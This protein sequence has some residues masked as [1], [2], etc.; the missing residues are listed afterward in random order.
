MV[1]LASTERQSGVIAPSIG[2][3]LKRKQSDTN[4]DADNLPSNEIKRRRVTFKHEV[5]VHI[6]PDPNEKSLEL[7]GEEVQRALEKHAEGNKNGGEDEN[8]NV[9]YDEIRSL[10]DKKPTSAGAPL[11]RLLE[12]YVI[13]LT[14]NIHLLDSSCTGLVRA[15]IDSHWAGRNESYYRLYRNLLRSLLSVHGGYTSS[16]LSMLVNKFVVPPS[17]ALRQQDDPSIQRLQIQQRVHDCL[18]HLLRHN[19][20]ASSSLGSILSATFP[21]P[22]DTTK[23]HVQYIQNILR[24]SEYCPELKGQILSLITDKLVKIDVQI[25]VDM[26]ELEDDIE[27][28][29]TDDNVDEEE[30]EDE[31]DMS[32]DESVSSE[33]SMDP[34]ERRIKELKESIAKLDGIMDLLFSHYHTVF[35]KGNGI[36]IEDTFESLLSQFANIILPTY[37]SRHTQFLLFHYSQTSPALINRFAGCCSQLAFDQRFPG[38]LRTA[39]A[40]FLVR[41]NA[42]NCLE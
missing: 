33:E 19:P 34:E 11:T 39:A 20:M 5:D 40:A 17:P 37:R 16:V 18:R 9:Q 35:A 30:D 32:D 3:S 1:S 8:G 10:F 26:D 42:S 2:S 24:V 31:D 25:Q 4:F 6:L 41:S 15:V 23:A 27:D 36:E 21:F 7:V 29:L 22:T 38:I 12:K 13:A 14:N 28:H